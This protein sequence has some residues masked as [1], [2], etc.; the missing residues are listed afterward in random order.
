M[1]LHF[2]EICNHRPEVDG[3]ANIVD[4]TEAGTPADE[5]PTIRVEVAGIVHQLCLHRVDTYK[6][7]DYQEQDTLDPVWI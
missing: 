4:R 1:C 5:F 2:A 3:S 7:N 6:H